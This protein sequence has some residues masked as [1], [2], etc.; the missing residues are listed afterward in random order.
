M[1]AGGR[2]ADTFVFGSTRDSH[3]GVADHI[4]AAGGAVAF[5]RP[6]HAGGDVIDLRGDRR[7]R[8]ARPATR[9]FIS[10]ARTRGGIS[11]CRTW[12][13]LTYVRGNTD[14]DPAAEFQ[15]IIHDGH[16]RA[17]AYGAHDF[18]L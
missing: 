9:R 8:A 18:L 15:L 11:G 13:K 10:A 1:L 6:G 2:G 17:A 7:R 16:V 14:A 5:E 4:V 12:A 3:G